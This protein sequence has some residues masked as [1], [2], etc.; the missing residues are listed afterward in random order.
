[1]RIDAGR[2]PRTCGSAIVMLAAI[3]CAGACA[4]A[5]AG[6]RAD[7]SESSPTAFVTPAQRE[8]ALA[9]ARVWHH[10]A[11]PIAKADLGANPSGDDA[12]DV[13][14]DVDCSFVPEHVGGST[15]KF[16]CRLR[17]GEVV[18]VKYGAGNAEVPAETAATRL[19]A[20]LGF[21]ADR[22]YVVHSVRCSA[23]PPF[24]FEALKCLDTTSA[25][26]AC[27]QGADAARPVT[28]DDAVIE[29]QVSGRRIA[30]S[31]DQGWSWF[32]LDRVDPA[33]GGS[34]RAHI[35]AL[36]LVAVILAHWDNKAENQRL[37]CP[38][39]QDQPDGSCHAPLLVVQDLGA[40]FG[41]LKLDLQNWRRVPVWL[42]AAECRV[43][44]RALPYDGGT[45]PDHLISEEGRQ[46]TLGLLRQLSR[47]QIA[48]LFVQS[49]VTRFNHVFAEA[50]NAEPWVDAFSAKIDSLASAG[51]CPSAA[52]LAGRRE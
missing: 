13:S 31:P 21:A 4:G 30:A 40:T 41:P 6:A 8:A 37:V 24:P 33:M 36:R 25:E 32:E 19:L 34:P 2:V 15:R 5:G 20:V 45:F 18:K 49:G 9:A 47:D 12:F 22:M 23:C 3:A 52:E 46:F 38:P 11:T 43:S 48:R 1:M 39:G 51:P 26:A 27:L 29:R 10:P 44:L 28:F 7:R 50:R 35:D 16:N 14:S 42:N 17:S